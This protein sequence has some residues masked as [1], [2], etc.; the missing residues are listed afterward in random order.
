MVYMH[1]TKK[2]RRGSMAAFT[3]A[4]EHIIALHDNH[5]VRFK[6]AYA[7]VYGRLGEGITVWEMDDTDSYR[8]I[9]D[10][11]LNRDAGKE[12]EYFKWYTIMVELIEEEV[13]A[14][15]RPIAVR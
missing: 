3:E 1:S 2:I 7:T 8:S 4:L 13:V 15:L 14:L 6:D 9:I 5:G 10:V 11:G 12:P